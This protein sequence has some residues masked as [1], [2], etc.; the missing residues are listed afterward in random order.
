[1]TGLWWTVRTEHGEVLL[2]RNGVLITKKWPSG[3]RALFQTS[4]R[5]T[6]WI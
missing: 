3:A 4:P 6:I 2:F 5:V 1:M